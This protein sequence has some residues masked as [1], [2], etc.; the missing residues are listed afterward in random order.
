MKLTHQPVSSRVVQ[1]VETFPKQALQEHEIYF[2]VPWRVQFVSENIE[3]YLY[4]LLFLDAEMAQKIMSHHIKLLPHR[5]MKCWQL[6]TT[7][8][9]LSSI[10]HISI[11]HKLLQYHSLLFL[12]NRDNW[13]EGAIYL[14]YYVLVEISDPCC[15]QLKNPCEQL[16]GMK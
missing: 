9:N 11:W 1:S 12:L 2:H 14:A 3:I 4:F 13:D 8:L 6:T 10:F 5:I 15:I 7:N 16:I